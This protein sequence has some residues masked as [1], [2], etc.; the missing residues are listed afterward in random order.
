MATT[1]D[2]FTKS[3]EKDMHEWIRTVHHIRTRT[4]STVVNS[5]LVKARSLIIIRKLQA[6]RKVSMCNGIDH[7]TMTDYQGNDLTV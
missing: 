3:I 5:G 4:G 2:E 6:I 7:G 1:I